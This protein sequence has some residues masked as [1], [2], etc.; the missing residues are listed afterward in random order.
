MAR[1]ITSTENS[2]S[3]APQPQ[4]A[5]APARRPKTTYSDDEKRLALEC[6]N[7]CAG[8]IVEASR[9]SGI[10]EFTLREWAR[11]N[12]VSESVFKE[13]A[14]KKAG[15]VAAKMRA[16]LDRV[17]DAMADENKIANA[18]LGELNTVAGT[19]FDKLRLVDGQPTQITERRLD[20]ATRAKALALLD[21][22]AQLLG[23]RDKARA[24]LL[25]DAPA[26]SVY[27]N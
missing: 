8:N 14:E 5:P 25:E 7:L 22:Y 18:R 16:L 4:E 9:L 21:E 23:D 12:C 20:E 11:G 10:P 2:A 26:L 17:I 24:A 19:M 6:V 13:Y 1:K 3:D 27:V 15:V